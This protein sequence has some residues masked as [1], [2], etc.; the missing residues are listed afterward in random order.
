MWLQNVGYATCGFLNR[1]I[2][3]DLLKN[4]IL[5]NSH[6]IHLAYRGVAAIALSCAF[7][8]ALI[9]V[10]AMRAADSTVMRPLDDKLPSLPFAATFDKGDGDNG[11][12]ILSLKNTSGDSIKASGSVLLSVAVH[13]N[14]KTRDIPEHTV[15]RDEVWTIPGLAAGDKVTIAASGFS[16]LELT[17]PQ[18]P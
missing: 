8:L 14:A 16:P 3:Y 7:G 13:N 9:Q 2:K 18:A 5:K 17:V 4:M 12:Y 15:G 6:S 11:P 10:P 1:E